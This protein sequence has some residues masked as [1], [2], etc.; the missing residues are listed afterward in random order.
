MTKKTLHYTICL[1]F[2]VLLCCFAGK[3]ASAKT[4]IADGATLLTS[5]ATQQIKSE[6]DRILKT[7]KTSVYIW[8]SSRIGKGDDF[9]A[10]MEKIAQSPKVDKNLV[11]LFISTKKKQHV[12]QILGYGKAKKQLTRSRCNRIMDRMQHDLT[13]KEYFDALHTFCSKVET[14]MGTEPFLDSILF[15]PLFHLILSILIGGGIVLFILFKGHPHITVSA[16]DYID[17]NHS[18]LLGH[19]DH[20][21]HITT[22][23]TRKTSSNSD[24]GGGSDH[25]S[26]DAHTF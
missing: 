18:Q 22:T 2:T 19:M 23:R 14:Y 26:G 10:Q 3:T 9:E 21:S 24:S 20:F 17:T 13:D 6:C 8:T 15:H 25:S 4:V 12:Y 16:K 11:L 5:D 7:Y 1:L